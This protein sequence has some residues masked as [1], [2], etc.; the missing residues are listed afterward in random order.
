[1]NGIKEDFKSVVALEQGSLGRKEALLTVATRLRDLKVQVLWFFLWDSLKGHAQHSFHWFLQSHTVEHFQ[2]EETELLPLL[3][4]AGV[5][6]KQQEALVCQCVEIME[7]MHARMFSFMLSGL[8]P[9]QIHQYLSLLQ[10]SLEESNKVLLTRMMTAL[11]QSDD[12]YAFV[13]GVV[14]ERLPTLA[15][16]AS[17]NKGWNLNLVYSVY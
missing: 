12:E 10:K 4:A 16:L 2:E 15:S 8:H 3:N 14:K 13:W 17:F 7:S 9:H 1:M 11:K 6:S 5:G